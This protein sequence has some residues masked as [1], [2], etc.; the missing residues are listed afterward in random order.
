[1]RT[2][3]W[4]TTT[5]CSCLVL[6]SGSRHGSRAGAGWPQQAWCC[7]RG[8]VVVHYVGKRE[9]RDAMRAGIRCRRGAPTEQTL[10]PEQDLAHDK[11]SSVRRA[12]VWEL[13]P[14]GRRILDVRAL[15]VPV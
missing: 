10:P 4:Q 13:R 11:G 5:C 14:D 15:V 8:T 9:A 7:C 1:M 3:D 6:L 12:R 2:G